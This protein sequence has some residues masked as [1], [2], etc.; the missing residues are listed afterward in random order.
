MHLAIVPVM[1]R[2]DFFLFQALQKLGA[3]KIFCRKMFAV[4]QLIDSALK[5]S[6]AKMFSPMDKMM[7]DFR[8]R[9][10]KERDEHNEEEDHKRE[11]Q[12]NG[13]AERLQSDPMSIILE[14]KVLIPQP[15]PE[16]S[17]SVLK[18]GAQFES[19]FNAGNRWGVAQKERHCQR[20]SAVQKV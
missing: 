17:L 13:V 19:F 14:A 5:K 18:C 15:P 12:E 1:T 9:E 16:S 20:C 2:Q 4:D 6:L 10:Q 11:L 8:K 7:A 3:Q